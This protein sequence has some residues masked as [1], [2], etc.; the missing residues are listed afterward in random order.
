ML[1]NNSPTISI[2]TPSYNQGHFLEDNI[3]SI[4]NQGYPYFEHIIIDNCSKDS[5]LSVVKKYP[6]VHFLSA[7]D[8]GQSDALNKALKILNGDIIGWLNVDEYYL[9]GTFKK[10][11]KNLSDNNLDGLYSNLEFVN[12]DKRHLRTLYSHKPVKWLSIFHCF[13]PSA[14]FFFRKQ[15]INS[16]ICFDIEFQIAMDQEFFAHI[17]FSEFKTFYIND[18]FSAFRWHG[19]NKSIDNHTTR[20]IRLMEGFEIFRRYSGIKIN[21]NLLTLSG[22]KHIANFLLIYRKFLKIIN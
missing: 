15:I 9:P 3:Q 20:S 22:Y 14:T 19:K 12:K 21:K 10:V 8:K 5:T 13:I 16:G 18:T 1:K 11:I 6:H 7:P 17:L 4:I 2:I